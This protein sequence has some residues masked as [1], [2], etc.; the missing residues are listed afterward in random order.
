M[1]NYNLKLKLDLTVNSLT[2]QSPQLHTAVVHFNTAP[3]FTNIN[4]TFIQ[5]KKNM[6]FKYEDFF[7]QNQIIYLPLPYHE[8]LTLPV[9]FVFPS[10]KWASESINPQP[11]TF[12]FSSF[13]HQN[14]IVFEVKFTMQ[15]LSIPICFFDGSISKAIVMLLLRADVDICKQD[16]TT[17][18]SL[19]FRTV[20]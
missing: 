7:F 14:V 12:L 10:M 4:D 18:N 15:F 1:A 8:R 16:K 19:S 2:I 6:Y 5:K 20:F 3:I 11:N 13:D 17:S 9:S